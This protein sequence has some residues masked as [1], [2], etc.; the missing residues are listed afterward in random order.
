[1]PFLCWGVL[2]PYPR[3]TRLPSRLRPMPSSALPQ[4]HTMPS[5]PTYCVLVPCVALDPTWLGSIS[6]AARY[7]T[8]AC[9][10]TLSQGFEKIQAARGYDFTPIFALSSDWEK[11]LAPSMAP[12][13]AEGFKI[14]CCLDRSGK[15]DDSSQNKEQKT[16][17][18]L[19]RDKLFGA[20]LC[21]T[22]LFTCLQ[23]SW[24]DQSVWHCGNSAS[25]ETCVA[26]RSFW[27]HCWF[28]YVTFAMGCAR[29]KDFTLKE[30]NK[31]VELDARMHPT[32]S[33]ITTSV[34]CGTTCL[35][36]CGCM[37]RH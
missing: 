10:T 22:N 26:R 31:R 27:T 30:R 20:R 28:F 36:L 29:Q 5:P 11:N 35:L 9:S 1:M 33:H 14:V 13:T 4:A 17:T 37:L 19:L 7:R 25:H 24:T 15:L 3:Q 32:L 6:L 16:A 12:S 18:A 2:D 8:A 21:Q 23:N 34:H